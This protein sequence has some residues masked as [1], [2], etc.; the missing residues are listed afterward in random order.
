MTD[1][2]DTVV[3]QEMC[4]VQLAKPSFF[5]HYYKCFR[6]T[7]QCIQNTFPGLNEVLFY[8]YLRVVDGEY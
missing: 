3:R 5:H 4:A 7:C 6:D 8:N 1:D 2:D